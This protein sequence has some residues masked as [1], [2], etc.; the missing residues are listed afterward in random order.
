MKKFIGREYEL[1]L[2]K[3]T[4]DSRRS[5]F[6]IVRGRRR[7]G[8][9]RLLQE[10]T[11]GRGDIIYVSGMEDV[12]SDRMI[13]DRFTE[14][15][16]EFSKKEI[17]KS[18]HNL[19]WPN[20]F[21][22]MMDVSEGHEKFTV[23]IDE[24][25]W[26]ARQ[27]S[28]FLSDLKEAWTTKFQPSGKIKIVICGSSSKFFEHKTAGAESVLYKLRTASDIF[29][30]PMTLKETSFF[31]KKKWN[32]HEIALTQMM[33]GGI[34]YYLDLIAMPERGFMQCINDIAFTPKTI[35]FDEMLETLKLDISST[36]RAI[37]LLSVIGQDGKTMETIARE[38]LIPTSTL[39][40]LLEKLVTYQ[41]LFESYPFG[42][43]RK[44]K[45]FGVR[46]YI[47]DEFLNFYFNVLDKQK[48]RIRNNTN[49]KMIF[50]HIL[51]DGYYINNF[52][53]KAFEL[54]IRKAVER[55]VQ[56][57]IHKILSIDNLPSYEVGSYWQMKGSV[58]NQ[59]DLMVDSEDD[60]C[61][62]IIEVKWTN[63]K[64]GAESGNA[65]EQVLTRTF[66]NRKKRRVRHFVVASS[67]FTGDAQKLAEENSVKL[68]ALDDIF[69]E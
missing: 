68:I 57:K 37:Q 33:F 30:L 64:I 24:I 54:L 7:V 18:V 32:R 69:D 2:L 28:G 39:D 12:N 50:N 21:Q 55:N 3:E 10:A 23:I 36:D 13:R 40:E 29:V 19:S 47:R 65:I 6:R 42:E 63:Q 46:Y 56:T 62:R 38:T 31:C 25:Q 52:T 14:K 1:A 8:K 17:L 53:G 27:G 5:E 49:N 16:A 11:K 35:F 20:I 41:I 60:R 26:L 4:L 48:N 45:D 15:L 66:P 43:P 51:V 58:G 9:T 22:T 44:S 34:P 67:G 61:T 59:I